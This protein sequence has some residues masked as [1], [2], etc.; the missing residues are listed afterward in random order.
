METMTITNADIQLLVSNIISKTEA[1]I[2][3]D[4]VRINNFQGNNLQRD[5]DSAWKAYYKQVQRRQ[6]LKRPSAI[7][8]CDKDIESAKQ[9]LEELTYDIETL[10]EQIDLLN[11]INKIVDAVKANGDADDI[12]IKFVYDEEDLLYCYLILDPNHKYLD[13]PLYCG[14]DTTFVPPFDENNNWIEGGCT[15]F[16]AWAYI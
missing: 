13:T 1:N 8:R 14:W 6:S 9:R 16:P 4:T 2:L 3:W 5:I 15:L 12:H 10:P 11:K 7:K